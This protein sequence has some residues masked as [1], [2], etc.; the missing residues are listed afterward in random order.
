MS[1]HN[2][3]HPKPAPSGEK[4]RA[5]GARVAQ[6]HTPLPLVLLPCGR[7]KL[8]ELLD[9]LL[10][11]ARRLQAEGLCPGVPAGVELVLAMD[12]PMAALNE[13][14]MGVPGPT[15]IL[16]F[17]ASPLEGEASLVLSSET[18]VRECMLYGQTPRDHLS[19]LLAHGVG[20]VC[21]FGH[22]E[23]MDRFTQRLEAVAQAFFEE[24]D[25]A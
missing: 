23:A 21:G 19:R 11:E 13:R 12:G 10:G 20:H 14:A 3:R 9:R 1:R 7:R 22:G 6:P 17:P 16:S 15:N 25:H 2:H 5:T 18:F 4:P 24:G 8:A